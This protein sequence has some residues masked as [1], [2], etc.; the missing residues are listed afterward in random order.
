M[1]AF[2]LGAMCGESSYEP[3]S[4]KIDNFASSSIHY[5]S[6]HNPNP[7]G[8]Q[9]QSGYEGYLVP[10]GSDLDGPSTF[11][12]LSTWDI[13]SSLIAPFPSKLLMFYN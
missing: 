3:A 13:V 12:G 6:W 8:I 5:N 10:P 1:S 11:L 4:D 9:L 2:L 7:T